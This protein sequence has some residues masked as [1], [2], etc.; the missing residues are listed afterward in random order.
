MAAHPVEVDDDSDVGDD[1]E[2]SSRAQVLRSFVV[3]AV[4]VQ[5]GPELVS[6]LMGLTA[7]DDLTAREWVEVA[8]AWKKV[9]CLATAGSVRRDR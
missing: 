2:S 5:P 4:S 8:V 1:V 9:T 6:A 7:R 3:S